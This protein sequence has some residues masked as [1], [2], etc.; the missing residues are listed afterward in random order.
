[1]IALG[2]SIPPAALMPLPSQVS[3]KAPRLDGARFLIDPAGAI[4]IVRRGSRRA[5]AI[6]APN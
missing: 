6:I 2:T 4:V 1:M 3:E 5:D